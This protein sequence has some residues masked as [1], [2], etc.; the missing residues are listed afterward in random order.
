MIAKTVSV[1]AANWWF[2]LFF[3]ILLLILAGL[4][5]AGI[6]KAGNGAVNTMLWL[7]FARFVHRAA[8]FNVKFAEANPDGSVDRSYGGFML[9]GLALLVVSL[10]LSLP[11]LLWTMGSKVT[12]SAAPTLRDVYPFLLALLIIYALVLSLAGSWLP[13]SVYKQNPGLGAALRRGSR[14]F[15]NVLAWI[16]PT[17]LLAIIVEFAA[18]FAFS[19]FNFNLSILSNGVIHPTGGLALLVVILI[20]SFSVSLISVVLSHYYLVAEGIENRAKPVA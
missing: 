8:L 12:A 19:L 6:L 17:L 9:K 10:I 15:F 13:A 5:D 3:A 20:E 16:A 14:T 18:L 4:A 1:I 2:Y 7:M 11:V